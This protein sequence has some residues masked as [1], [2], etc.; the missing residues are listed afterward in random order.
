MGDFFEAAMK[1]KKVNM[2]YCLRKE[3]AENWTVF[4]FGAPENWAKDNA[5]S[6]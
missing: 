6:I 1:R 2:Q 5:T 4:V 3:R